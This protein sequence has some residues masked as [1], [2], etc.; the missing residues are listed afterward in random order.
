L[1][2]IWASGLC[3]IVESSEPNANSTDLS[4]SFDGMKI[5]LEPQSLQNTLFVP[6]L[7]TYDF[8]LLS[9]V[10]HLKFFF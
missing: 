3:G 8:S 1:V 6:L 5:K 2:N 9:P 10:S 4:L 7:A